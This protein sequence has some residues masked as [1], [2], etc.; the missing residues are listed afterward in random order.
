MTK[1]DE[2]LTCLEVLNKSSEFLRAKGV[3][4]PKCDSEWIV[5]S[6]LQKKENGTLSLP[7]S[8]NWE[9]KL[10]QIRSYIVRRGK[11][12]PLQHILGKRKLYRT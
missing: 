5:S 12:E 4:S 9:E 11:R 2:F 3:A 8:N 10:K 1:K 6:I 7:G